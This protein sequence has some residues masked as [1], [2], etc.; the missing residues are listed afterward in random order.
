[1]KTIFILTFLSISLFAK[2]KLSWDLALGAGQV[3]GKGVSIRTIGFHSFHDDLSLFSGKFSYGWGMRGS[4]IN[5]NE[6]AIYKEDEVL[7]DV[8]LSAYNIGLYTQYQ[9]EKYLLGLNI[10]IFGFTMGNDS[11][12]K[13]T[14]NSE[15]PID[16]NILLGG[17]NDQG[18]LNSE[19]WIGYQF[20]KLVLR[21]GLSH[22]VIEYEGDNPK[23]EKRQ[24]FFDA[25]FL[26]AQYTF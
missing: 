25:F 4:L 16:I 19:F 3:E 7:E 6:F 1:M 22:V 26:A 9:Q 5:A 12:I 10:D 18:T 13:G 15:S 2:D 17:K 23:N 21:G 11:D 20:N 14:N 24:R 8:L